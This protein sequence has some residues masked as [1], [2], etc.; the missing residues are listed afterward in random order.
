MESK[1]LNKINSDLREFYP[2]DDFDIDDA[3]NDK[4][5]DKYGDNKINIT[6]ISDMIPWIE[7]YRPKTI[8]EI[9]LDNNTLK[10]IENIIQEKDMPNIIITGV[11]GIGKTTT[12]QCIARSFF[13]KNINKSIL[14]INASDDRGIKAV[15][16]MIITFCKKKI[17]SNHKIIILDEADNMTSKAQ[18]LINVLMEKYHKTT[19]FAFTCNNSSDIIEAIQSR[20]IIF[21]Y[22]RLGKEQIIQR[23]KIIC[24]KEKVPYEDEALE[25]LAVSSQGDMRTAI[26]NLQLT[27]NGIGEVI[28][29]N[30]YKMCDKPQSIIIKQIFDA[31][32]NKDVSLAI[33]TILNLKKNGFSG[34]D[35]MLS[36]TNT[37]KLAD[38]TIDE[39]IK[40]KL[41][42]K[43]SKASYIISRG[44][45]S[46]L[47]LIGCISDIILSL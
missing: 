42:G 8:E 20:C 47:Q 23:L 34:S 35:I 5:N 46:D 44:I 2:H 1:S 30:V 39:S 4:D 28:I 14:E 18:R 16:E 17:E 15:Q 13:G 24:D 19:R 12:I 38:Y 10:K 9:V 37:L 7:K 29:D 33:K 22:Y 36:M 27:C 3:I 32:I 11:P 26:N 40:I 21:R 25:E 6:P 43:V 31:C 41:L 45:D